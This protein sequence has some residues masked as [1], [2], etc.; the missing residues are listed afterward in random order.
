MN[1]RQAHSSLR[2]GLRQKLRARGLRLL[3]VQ[4]P[5]IGVPGRAKVK[6]AERERAGDVDSQ[7]GGQRRANTRAAARDLREFLRASDL[8]LRL[9]LKYSP[10]RDANVVVVFERGA[11]QILQLGFAKDF[12]PLLVGDGVLRI[13]DD[14]S[15]VGAAKSRRSRNG[16]SIVSGSDIAT[17]DD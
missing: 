16:W 1:Q 13:A 7:V 4:A 12:R 14:G 15:I 3:A 10:R 6:G 17:G 5:E 9:L 8:N 2:P 11:N